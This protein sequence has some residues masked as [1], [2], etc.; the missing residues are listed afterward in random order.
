MMETVLF[1][2]IFT[3]VV[4]NTVVILKVGG[5]GIGSV[6]F[7]VVFICPADL[8]GDIEGAPRVGDIDGADVLFKLKLVVGAVEGADGCID[9]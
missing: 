7:V 9:G 8:V 5:G 1:N 6:P 3:V 2:T 4:F